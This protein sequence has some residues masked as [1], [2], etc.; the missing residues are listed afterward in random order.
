MISLGSDSQTSPRNG[1]EPTMSL[2]PPELTAFAQCYGA[3]LQ[4]GFGTTLAAWSTPRAKRKSV[5]V[6]A[7]CISH[8]S[9]QLIPLL[10]DSDLIQALA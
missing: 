4:V 7:T 8:R 9:G 3:V 5:V 10:A 6:S 1:P 2:S